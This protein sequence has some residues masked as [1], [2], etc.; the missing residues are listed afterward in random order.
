MAY[1]RLY[2]GGLPVNNPEYAM[3]PAA[4]INQTDV[5]P[6]AAHK[7][8]IY[9]GNT[10]LFDFTQKDIYRQAGLQQY[11]DAN[12]IAQG[13]VIGASAC[14]A[15]ALLHGFAWGVEVAEA[16]V[17]MAATLHYQ[18]TTLDTIDGSVVGSNC[19]LLATPVWLAA[20]D[21][22]DLTL[23]AWP[24]NGVG[25]LRFWVTPLLIVPQRGN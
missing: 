11:L 2:H 21:I 6:Q 9:F 20:S 16:G 8:P 19:K 24:A 17:S 23:T 14:S 12:P 22:V 7:A 5:L 13:D 10:R 4:Q 15:P 1:H 18:G 25:D 3:Y